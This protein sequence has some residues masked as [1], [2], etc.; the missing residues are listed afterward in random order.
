MGAR[1]KKTEEPASWALLTCDVPAY[2]VISKAHVLVAPCSHL[3]KIGLGPKWLHF[4]TCSRGEGE[5][6]VRRDAQSTKG[7]LPPRVKCLTLHLGGRRV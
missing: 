5:A 6:G 1:R 4:M 2:L 7:Q 3:R